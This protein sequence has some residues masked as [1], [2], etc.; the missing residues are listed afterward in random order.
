MKCYI[1]AEMGKDTDAVAVCT[2]CGAGICREHAHRE[3]KCA[4]EG[5]YP[6]P[7]RKLENMEQR[8]LCPACFALHEEH[9]DPAKG[10]IP[11]GPGRS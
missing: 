4:W 10:T 8:M 11:T 3:E 7:S 5:N 2:D 6:F 1:C 9:N